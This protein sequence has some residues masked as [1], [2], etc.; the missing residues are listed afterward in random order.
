MPYVIEAK[1]KERNRVVIRFFSIS[2]ENESEWVRKRFEAK[3]YP[4]ERL[5]KQAKKMIGDP[6]LSKLR[7]DKRNWKISIKSLSHQ[8]TDSEMRELVNECVEG[9]VKRTGLT[10]VTIKRKIKERI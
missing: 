3:S 2:N 10:R 6:A 4:S 8:I 5:A 1:K 9:L 7:G